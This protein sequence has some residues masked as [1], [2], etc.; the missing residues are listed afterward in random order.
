M[1]CHRTS[2]RCIRERTLCVTSRPAPRNSQL[3]GTWI[4]TQSWHTNSRNQCNA[5]CVM[6]CLPIGTHLQVTCAKCTRSQRSTRKHIPLI[7]C[8]NVT[9]AQVLSRRKR[10]FCNTR[11]KGKMACVKLKGYE[12]AMCAIRL[13]PLDQI[14]KDMSSRMGVSDTALAAIFAFKIADRCCSSCSSYCSCW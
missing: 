4:C 1:T 3:S 9:L 5:M 12:P 14:Y 8:T 7:N 11:R 10:I 13:S 2:K 6:Y